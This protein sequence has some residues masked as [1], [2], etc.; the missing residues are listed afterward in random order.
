MGINGNK[1]FLLL[2][3]LT[4]FEIQNIRHH[5]MQMPRTETFLFFF[6]NVQY[7]EVNLS[8]LP[9]LSRRDRIAISHVPA[10]LR[11]KTARAIHNYTLGYAPRCAIHWTIGR[12]LFEA[13]LSREVQGL[14]Q[15][16]NLDTQKQ[17]I[18]F[19]ERLHFCTSFILLCFLC[20]CYFQMY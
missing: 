2:G 6:A 9:A 1:F 12:A 17:F 13:V 15:K 3:D 7:T 5:Q 16:H 14:F 11:P 18:T 10:G 20:W 4:S 19:I 8:W